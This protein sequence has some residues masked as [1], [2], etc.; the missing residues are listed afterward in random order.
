MVRVVWYEGSTK[1]QNL[2][3]LR[4]TS[5]LLVVGLGTITRLPSTPYPYPHPTPPLDR[6]FRVLALYPLPWPLQDIISRLVVCA[7][8][9]RPF[10]LPARLHCT[11]A[12]LLHDYWAIYDSPS[13]SL[14]HAI[15]FTRLVI[16]ISCKGQALP[17]LHPT[18]GSTPR[19]LSVPYCAGPH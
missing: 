17:P 13:T 16:T 14:V 6:G 7:R 3:F 18:S 1:K 11:V 19:Y 10:I 15:H 5:Y 2:R 9:N 12:I 8:I 4:R